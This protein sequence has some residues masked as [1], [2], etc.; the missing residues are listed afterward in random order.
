MK[1]ILPVLAIMLAVVALSS[2]NPME[3]KAKR[4]LHDTMK[5]LA[6]NPETF[7]ISNA[8]IVFS[9]DSMCTISFIGIGQNAFGGYSSSKMEY[10]LVKEEYEGKTNYTETI[11][12]MED[13]KE[14]MR[15]IKEAIEDIDGGYLYGS[16]KEIYNHSIKTG[17]TKEEA[18]AD[19]LY[20][21]AILNNL[22]YGR[23]VESDD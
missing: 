10:T 2:C 19:C 5:E 23:K 7:K 16:T 3:R 17:K 20:Y 12:D 4:Q 1:K 13:S 14:K 22:A 21:Q 8:K 11:L 18:K 6:K 9:N 15:S